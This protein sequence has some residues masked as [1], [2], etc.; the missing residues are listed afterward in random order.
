M[1]NSFFKPDGMKWKVFPLFISGVASA[2]WTQGEQ[3]VAQQSSCSTG[4]QQQQQ[5]QHAASGLGAAFLAV[6]GSTMLSFTDAS[7]SSLSSSPFMKALTGDD[8]NN[9]SQSS[10]KHNSSSSSSSPT[11]SLGHDYL[12]SSSCKQGLRP[13]MEDEVFVRGN[14]VAV[15]DGHGGKAVS[16]YLRQNLY[17]HMQ[18]FLPKFIARSIHRTSAEGPSEDPDGMHSAAPSSILDPL[19][20][21]HLFASVPTVEECLKALQAAVSKVDE[22]VQR[23]RHWSY[24]GS[25]VVAVWVHQ[26]PCMV[27][28][29]KEG[30]EE[31]QKAAEGKRTLIV[32]NVGDSRAVLNR[33][34]TAIELTRDHKPND[35]VEQARIEAMGGKVKWYGQVDEHGQPDHMNGVYR[36]NGNLALAR[37]VGDRS[38]RPAVTCDVETDTHPIEDGDQ[39]VLLASDGLWDVMSSQEAVDFVNAQLK[40]SFSF[41]KE[42]VRQEMARYLSSEALRLGSSDNVSVIVLWLD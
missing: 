7:S 35:P 16:T 21:I 36:V 24:Q 38:E 39:F 37:T 22:E 41:R 17:A 31:I 30:E 33:N 3:Y 8:N 42:S 23:I 4:E 2:W 9:N 40:A 26:E 19:S 10:G 6:T 28:E 12:V 5:Q 27:T 25:T 11:S 13:Y 1:Q 32:A 18:A 20:K 15:F 29:S 34:G 14:F